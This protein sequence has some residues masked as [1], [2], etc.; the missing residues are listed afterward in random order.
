M[1][2]GIGLSLARPSK[3]PVVYVL[4]PFRFATDQ[5]SP[6]T[7]PYTEAGAVGSL[8]LVQVD[9][10]M[11]ASGGQLAWTAQTTPLD[12]DQG[13]DYATGLAR[14]TGRALLVDATLTGITNSAAYPLAWSRSA[15]V[16]FGSRNNQAHMLDSFFNGQASTADLTVSANGGNS[17]TVNAANALAAGT[18]YQ[19]AIVLRPTGAHYLIK[20]GAFAAWTLLYVENVDSTATVYPA[21]SSKSAAGNLDNFRVTDLGGAWATD[22]GIATQRLA[23]ARAAADAFAHTANALLEFT[24]TTLPSAGSIDY[25]FRR[26]DS[27]NKWIARVSTTGALSL[28][29]VVAAGETSRASAAGVVANGNRVVIVAD[30]STIAGYSSNTSR[31]S[32]GSASTFQAAT[33][34]LLGSLGTG[35]A[36]SDIV[37]WPRNPTVPGV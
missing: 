33:S 36:V 28:I 4:G 9:G 16:N 5:G 3:A 32:Y 7:T 29:E 12:G 15:T 8:T 23:G 24:V 10:T 22:Y 11:A 21:F 2:I 25:E 14:A 19:L 30:G 6:L 26:Q 1:Q 17:N 34:G 37:A 35:G 27:G 31:W 13:F 18:T 20:G